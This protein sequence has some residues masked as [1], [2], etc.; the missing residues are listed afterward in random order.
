MKDYIALKPTR[1]FYADIK[2]ITN[3]FQD[4]FDERGYG[5]AYK[6]KLSEVHVAVKIL[7]NSKGNGKE[8]I[9][10]VGTMGRITMST[11]FAWLAFVLVDLGELLFMSSYHMSPWRSLYFQEQ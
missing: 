2:K 8:F 6:E 1:Y 10:E 11:L 5:T 7:N 4:K 3:Q 9:S